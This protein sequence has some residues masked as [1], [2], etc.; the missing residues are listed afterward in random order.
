MTLNDLWY[1]QTPENSMT[2]EFAHRCNAVDRYLMGELTLEE[3]REFE[4]HLF[5]CPICAEDVHTGAVVIDNLK[6]IFPDYEAPSSRR[7]GK[8]AFRWMQWFFFF[9]P[10][11]LLPTLAALALVIVVGYQNLVTIPHLTAPQVLAS[12]LIPPLARDGA[13]VVYS[14]SQQKQLNLN[15]E[16]DSP[17]NYKSYTATFHREGAGTVLTMDSGPRDTSSFVLSFL[18]PAKLFPPANYVMILR[19]SSEPQ[20][21]VSRYNFTVRTGDGN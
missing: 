7:K 17:A 12:N 21:E 2:H 11:T 3:C 13:P 9:R 20:V 5:C 18:V 19:P 16:V 6:E 1:S 15:F 14:S 10:T 4:E 8:A